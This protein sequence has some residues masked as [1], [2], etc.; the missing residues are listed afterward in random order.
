MAYNEP[1]T[2][3]SKRDCNC[4]ECGVQIE[5]GEAIQFNPTSKEVMCLKCAKNKKNNEGDTVRG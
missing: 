4:S 3:V 2:T 1:R 5:K